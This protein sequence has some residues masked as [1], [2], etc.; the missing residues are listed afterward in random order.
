MGPILNSS[1]SLNLLEMS[2][3]QSPNWILKW[4]WIILQV[5]NK[6]FRNFS[7]DFELSIKLDHHFWEICNC[8]ENGNVS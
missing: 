4:K 6:L 3:T 7:F 1:S 2:F 8:F 5:W